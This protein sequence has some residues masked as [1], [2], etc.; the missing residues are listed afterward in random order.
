VED[1]RVRGGELK[2]SPLRA[3]TPEAAEDLAD[4]LYGMLPNARITAVLAEC[5][6]G[7]GS[8]PPSP[9]CTPNAPH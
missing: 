3:V 8:P 6:A 2:V 7:P 9:T 4:R 5:T 1:V